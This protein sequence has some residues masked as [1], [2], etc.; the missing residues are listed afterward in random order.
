MINQVSIIKLI[1][2]YVFPVG[3]VR[4]FTTRSEKLKYPFF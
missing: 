2:A 3:T 4:Y 1:R